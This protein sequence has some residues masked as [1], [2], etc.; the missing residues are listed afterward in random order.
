MPNAPT[1]QLLPRVYPDR[2]LLGAAAARDIGDALVRWLGP[3][4]RRPSHLA[5]ALRLATANPGRFAS[6]RGTLRPGAAADL[7]TFAWRPGDRT[8][9]I[10]AVVARGRQVAAR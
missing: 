7:I 5:A 6:G 9:D 8:L 1:Y 3:P 10:H 2:E 4:A